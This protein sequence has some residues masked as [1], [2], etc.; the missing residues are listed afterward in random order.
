MAVSHMVKETV[1]VTARSSSDLTD[2][3]ILLLARKYQLI[4]PGLSLTSMPT[5]TSS[6][7]PRPGIR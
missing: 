3:G 6:A 1:I 4:S 5:R 2:S 7:S